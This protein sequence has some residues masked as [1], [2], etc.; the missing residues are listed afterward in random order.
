M[1]ELMIEGWSF[2]KKV[3]NSTS[4]AFDEPINSEDEWQV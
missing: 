4:Q 1:N 3:R 2:K